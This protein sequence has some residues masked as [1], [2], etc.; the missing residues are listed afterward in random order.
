MICIISGDYQLLLIH[1]W[2]KNSSIFRDKIFTLKASWGCPFGFSLPFHGC[3]L[4]LLMSLFVWTRFTDVS[5]RSMMPAW[6]SESSIAL[7]L[8]RTCLS[9]QSRFSSDCVRSLVERQF[10][11]ICD[12]SS[13]SRFLKLQNFLEFSYIHIEHLALSRVYETRIWR[14]QC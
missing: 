11:I 9:V 7:P 12:F 13:R 4:A 5:P 2:V 6:R 14:I 8:S 1:V 10:C 3:C